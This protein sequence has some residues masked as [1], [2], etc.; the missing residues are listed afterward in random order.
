[1]PEP[2]TLDAVVLRLMGADAMSALGVAEHVRPRGVC[3]RL[4]TP[5]LSSLSLPDRNAPLRLRMPMGLRSAFHDACTA[6][7][8]TMSEVFRDAMAAYIR[9]HPSDQLE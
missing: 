2:D 8:R 9:D 1:M 5:E 7:G 4:Y 3:H 6:Q